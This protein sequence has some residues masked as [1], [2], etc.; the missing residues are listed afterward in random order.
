MRLLD[1]GLWAGGRGAAAPGACWTGCEAAVALDR[2]HDFFDRVT[3]VGGLPPLFGRHAPPV[4]GGVRAAVCHPKHL[5]VPG[6]PPSGLPIWLLEV[7]VQR[8]AGN[9]SLLLQ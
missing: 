1:L 5:P 6:Q 8:V 7:A 4:R 9:M 2:S 3:D